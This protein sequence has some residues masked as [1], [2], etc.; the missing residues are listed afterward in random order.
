M[1]KLGKAVL[2]VSLVGLMAPCV[3]HAADVGVDGYWS[4]EPRFSSVFLSIRS[5]PF[6]GVAVA[7]GM[8]ETVSGNST[9]PSLNVKALWRFHDLERLSLQTSATISIAYSLDADP[10]PQFDRADLLWMM[11]LEYRLSSSNYVTVGLGTP[12]GSGQ[13]SVLIGGSYHVRW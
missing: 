13:I 1:N 4:L 11:E 12:I 3:S 9:R 7:G 6:S 5:W 10:M 8:G 2:I